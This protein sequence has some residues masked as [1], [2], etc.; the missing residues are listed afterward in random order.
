MQFFDSLPGA[1]PPEEPHYTVPAWRQPPSGEIPVPVPVGRVLTRAPGAVLSLRRI[2]A[3]SVGCSFRLQVDALRAS[4]DDDR[5]F[6][7]MEALEHRLG[8]RRDID[9]QARFGVTLADGRRASLDRAWRM[10]SP[11]AETPNGP[12]LSMN[13]RGGGGSDREYSMGYRLWLWPLPPAGPLT[14]HFQWLD[15]G[16][17][18]GSVVVDAEQI[19]AVSAGVTPLWE[20]LST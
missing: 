15:L 3:Y 9:G 19:V 10:E 17:P 12:V 5:W 2:D 1:E 18:E 6:D 16:V 4:V 11:G 7:I 8:R 14:L 20:P 13:H